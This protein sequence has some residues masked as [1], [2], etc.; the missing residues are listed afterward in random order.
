MNLT[1]FDD[2]KA[3]L[4]R[5]FALT[6]PIAEMRFGAGTL[7]ERI[8]DWAGIRA[9]GTLTRS[10]LGSFCEDGAPPA[11]GRDSVPFGEDTLLVS[12]RFVPHDEH[13][14]GTIGPVDQT[15]VLVC[16]DEVAGCLLPAGADA[17]DEAWLL[18]PGPLP[19]APT[20]EV[21]GR[22]LESAWHLV[23][24]GPTRLARDVARLGDSGVAGGL[25]SG[26]HRIG[27]G[28]VVLGADVVVEPGVVFDTTEGGV[29]L[30]DR[31]VVR[32][33]ARL[34]GPIATGSDCRLLGGAYACVSAGDRSYLR[35]EIEESIVL[36]YTNKA[37]DGFLGHAVVGRWV[38][39]GALTTNSDL[40]STYGTVSLGGPDGPVDTGLR[41][42]G[43]LIGDHAKTA[44]GTLLT[45][46][47]IVSAGASIFGE[48]AP[49]RWVPPFSWG[50]EGVACSYDLERFLGTAGVVLGRRGVESTEQVRA[51][52]S[53]CWQQAGT[54]AGVL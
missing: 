23:E 22:M 50:S 32:A 8:E 26:A 27:D 9:D 52:L 15:T 38:N 14:G 46:G 39:F 53:A 43:C 37:H 41:K 31:T 10:W 19:G 20:L 3:D 42:M 40:K 45:T 13:H 44:I 30:G 36:G 24:F 7:R 16:R 1:L 4:W 54:E 49:G 5:P 2:A 29:V 48:R 47:T 51:W 11:L 18:D 17:P 25:P 33:G 6:R 34:Q 35:G 21:P 12:S 28:P